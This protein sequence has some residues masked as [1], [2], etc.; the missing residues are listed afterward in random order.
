M[1]FFKSEGNDP[2]SEQRKRV[3]K[4]TSSFKENTSHI[5]ASETLTGRC[6]VFYPALVFIC[7]SQRSAAYTRNE[8]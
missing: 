6:A 7:D 8:F 4:M 3:K 1:E 2:R 5:K